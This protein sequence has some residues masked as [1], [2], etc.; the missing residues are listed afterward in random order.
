MK[1]EREHQTKN[2]NEIFKALMYQKID[3]VDEENIP[4]ATQVEIVT[5]EDERDAQQ[6][7]ITEGGLT[8]YYNNYSSVFWNETFRNTTTAIN[9]PVAIATP[10][11]N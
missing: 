8:G 3:T 2:L 9:I 7:Q 1:K 11:N 5:H 4:E 6:G 10:V